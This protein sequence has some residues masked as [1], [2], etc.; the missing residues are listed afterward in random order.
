MIESRSYYREDRCA[1]RSPL[2]FLGMIA[3]S[4]LSMT[5]AVL[6]IVFNLDWLIAIPFILFGPFMIPIGL[7]Y[8]NWP[9]GIRIDSQGIRIGAVKS[10]RAGRRIP[11][12]THQNWGLFSCP[13]ANIKH[14]AVV[15]DATTLREI[16]SSPRFYTLSNRWGKPRVMVKCML[17]VLS[18]PFM[19]AALVIELIDTNQ[20]GLPLT[21]S[22]S[23]FPN[24]LGRPFR[25]QLRSEA[26]PVWI[27]PT[28]RPGRLQE[29]I[30]EALAP[31]ATSP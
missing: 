11:T 17:G 31:N 27:V 26:G 29:V 9:T 24:E 1:L 2:L 14:L 16:R 22:A 15:S 20:A 18:A 23:F 25:V 8:R 28:R 13:W 21:R 7:L 4:A 19:R 12:V 6:G 10:G 5:A 30:N 3:P